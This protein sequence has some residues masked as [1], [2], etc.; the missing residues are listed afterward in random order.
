MKVKDIVSVI[1]DKVVI[2]KAKGEGIFEDIYKGDKYDIP[3][4]ILEMNI[5]A[6][7]AL[8]KGIVDIQ[9]I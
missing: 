3:S 5:K 7:G 4:N 6:I 1:F 2:Y 8:R 9:V